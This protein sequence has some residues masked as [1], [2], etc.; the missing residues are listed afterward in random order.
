MGSA[1]P[2]ACGP[3]VVES[4]DGAEIV[5]AMAHGAVTAVRPVKELAAVRVLVTVTTVAVRD[6]EL[7]MR[8]EEARADKGRPRTDS[9]ELTMT[10]KARNRSVGALEAEL[11]AFVHGHVDRRGTESALVVTP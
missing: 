5:Q 4:L 6:L 1:K 8:P 10:F 7:Q 11:E 2:E 3:I 9:G